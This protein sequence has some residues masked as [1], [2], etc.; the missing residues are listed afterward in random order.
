MRHYLVVGAGPVGS[1]IALNLAKDGDQVRVLTR[2][3]NGPIH[4]NITL[5]RGDASMKP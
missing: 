3:G 5:I 4:Q 1:T 2:S